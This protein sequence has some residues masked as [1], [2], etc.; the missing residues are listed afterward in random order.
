MCPPLHPA[1]VGFRRIHVNVA[2]RYLN[3]KFI[4][5]SV[6]PVFSRCNTYC[7]ARLQC[8][9]PE[10]NFVA[11]LGSKFFLASQLFLLPRHDTTP[12]PQLVIFFPSHP[13]PS[14]PT[15]GVGVP[16]Y[17]YKGWE[18]TVVFVR[19]QPKKLAEGKSKVQLKN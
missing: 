8:F 3:R 12:T 10:A 13:Q 15:G 17:H 11:S 7:L 5:S 19:K 18:P 4:L 14:P 9:P 6:S 16:Y 2:L 1:V